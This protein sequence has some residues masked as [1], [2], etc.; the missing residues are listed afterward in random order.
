MLAPS[1]NL[2]I[3]YYAFIYHPTLKPILFRLKTLNID[4]KLSII[5]KN[6]EELEIELFDNPTIRKWFN[7]FKEMPNAYY[8]LEISNTFR[9]RIPEGTIIEDNWENIL[10]ALNILNCNFKIEWVLKKVPLKFDYNQKTLNLLHRFFTSNFGKMDFDLINQINESV[11]ELEHYTTPSQNSIFY[12]ENIPNNLH[13]N[14]NRIPNNKSPWL[15]FSKEDQQLNYGYLDMDQH[16]L[17]LLDQS[18]LGKCILQSFIDEDDPTQNDCSGRLGSFGGFFIDLNDNRPK[19]YKSK[20]FK[21]WIRSHN[22]EIENLPYEF[23]IGYVKNKRVRK[24]L[25]Y[26]SIF[27]RIEFIE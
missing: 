1:P 21:D 8:R 19:I 14:V 12:E 26:S 15:L 2:R 13:L 6:T 4:M 16:N 23:P 3:A 11:H 9:K 5:F 27:E 17:V 22:M 7:H 10:Q 18:I 25:K 24:F 20:Q